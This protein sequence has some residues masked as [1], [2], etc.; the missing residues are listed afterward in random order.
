[1]IDRAL[2]VEADDLRS[3]AEQRRRVRHLREVLLQERAHHGGAELAGQLETWDVRRSHVGDPAASPAACRLVFPA[4]AAAPSH[5]GAA[6]GPAKYL[7][8]LAECLTCEA[9]WLSA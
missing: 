3:R 4:W 5:G 9:D 1:M 8:V 2:A 7:P 6:A